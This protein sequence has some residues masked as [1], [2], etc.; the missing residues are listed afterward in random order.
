MYQSARALYTSKE[1]VG[2]KKT[3]CDH[4]DIFQRH[5]SKLPENMRKVRKA[6]KEQEETVAADSV[7]GQ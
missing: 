6:Q 4:C 5:A 2:R 7:A 3:V 1:W